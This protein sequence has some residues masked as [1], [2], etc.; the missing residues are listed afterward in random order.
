MPSGTPQ[1]ILFLRPDTYGDLLLFE[2]VPRLVR[3]FWPEA[4]VAVLIR[5]PYEDIIPLAGSSGARWLTTDCNPYRENPGGNPAAFAALRETV[6]G[7]APDCVVAAC[8]EQTWLEAAVASFLPD[9][10]QISLGEGM[11]DPLARAALDAVLP[12]SWPDIYPEKV[13][14]DLE[15]R[16]WDKNLR[17]ASALLGR[18]VPRWWPSVQV[19]AADRER[20]ARILA[21]AG[22]SPGRFVACA[23]AGTANVKIK[24]WPAEHYGDTVAWLERERGIR[25]LLVGHTSEGAPLEAVR[26]RAREGGADPALWTGQDGE[27]PLLAALLEASG[28]YFGNDTGALH[29]AAALGRPVAP[30]FGGGTWPRFRPVAR[31][32][33]LVVQPLPCFGCGWN[34]YFGYAPCLREIPPAAA[35]R[36][37]DW[38]LASDEESEVEITVEDAIPPKALD[39][40]RETTAA[41]RLRTDRPGGDG[42]PSQQALTDLF[43][44]LDFSETDRTERLA[45]IERQ[46]REVSG[47]QQEVDRLLKEA[48]GFWPQLDAVKN[49]RNLLR[50]QLADLRGQFQQ[51][52][53]A[54]WELDAV[55]NERNLL[56]AQLADL[57]GQF[58]GL[59]ADNAARLEVIERQGREVSGLQQEV[60]RL[61]KEA[62]GFWPQ[63][64]AVKN[65]RNLLRAQLADLRG[66]FT[67]LEADNAARLEVI[68][69]Q[70]REVSGLQQEVD[71]LL[72]E[73]GGFWPQLDA[74]KNERNLLRAQLADLRGQFTGLEADNAARLEVIER[75][76][77]EVSGL[78]Q[79][80][81]RLLKEA[82]GFWPQLD[83]VKNERNLLRAQ[84]ADLRAH[85]DKGEADRAARLEA[86]HGQGAEIVR[87]Q[88]ETQRGRHETGA[89]Q[90][91]LEEAVRE[92][93]ARTAELETLRARLAHSEADGAAQR[94]SLEDREAACCLLQT[95]LASV[96]GER[97][98]LRERRD[99]LENH[100]AARLLKR[101]GLWPR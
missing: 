3:H 65:E 97:E 20:A 91:K 95:R 49:E 85:F 69:R 94:A 36:A 2:P 48:G 100:G 44:Q 86:L 82:G 80:V 5:K 11:T 39:L 13:P 27:M 24:S 92:H 58:T 45:T 77:R 73:A 68:E 43:K 78:Q 4:E 101:V 1:R 29:L 12:V 16:Q 34:C 57:R 47:L 46:G 38:L 31:R 53:A 83:A 41:L 56:R 63:L 35:R 84:L 96:E 79:E 32:A 99:T 88:T 76:G 18:E 60:D 25:A 21:A 19:P 70:G 37:L 87:L 26:Q 40:I 23:A 54:W 75:Q 66:Q 61:L 28:F 62:G 42:T 6:R 67:G 98:A 90:A 52:E 33:A 10:R 93:D 71:R 30:I 15:S 51:S 89:L 14:V 64:D 74:V 50:A 72:K 9:A 81:D 59:E 7:F 17:L 22:L 8:A 55:K